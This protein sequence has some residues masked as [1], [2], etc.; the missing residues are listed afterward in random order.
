[1]SFYAARQPILDKQK[2][3][4]AYEL[5]YRESLKN[6][7]PDI[8][9]D[10]ATAKLIEGLQFNLGLET[11]TQDSIAFINFTHS[12]LLEGYPLLLPKEKVVV[13]I[14]ETAKPS[15]KLLKACIDLKEKGYIIALDDYEH[16]KVWIHFFP[17]IDIIKLD[18]S[19]TSEDQF[20]EILKATKPYPHI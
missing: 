19:L 3:L 18:Y 8:N 17:Y 16:S 13:E 7:F 10:E 20:Q 4:F 6:F 2:N 1:M 11:L 9:D 5:L 14:L 15:K 12:S